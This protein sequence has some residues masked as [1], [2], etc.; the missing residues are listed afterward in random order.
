[1]AYLQMSTDTPPLSDRLALLR[2]RAAL[3]VRGEG[4]LP[5]A[6]GTTLHGAFGRALKLGVC[7]FPD[8][9]ERPCATCP[10]RESC[11]YPRLFEPPPRSRGGGAPPPAVGLAPAPATPRLVRPGAALGIDL[12]LIGDAMP[13]LSVLLAAL[14]RMA[15]DGLGPD[16]LPCAVLRVDA[17]DAAGR[18]AAP[19][20]LGAH[21]LDR[22][23]AA[24]A[25][26]AWRER[27][28]GLADHPTMLTLRV[29]TRLRLQREHVATGAAPSFAELARALVRRADALARSHCGEDAPFPD[30]R[31]WLD[32]AGT[33]RLVEARI[34]W[35]R[36][37][38]RS[39]STGHTM[40]LDGFTGTLTYA[41]EPGVLE[42][43][44]PL[45]LLGEVIGVG[46]G[47]SF[48]NGRYTVDLAPV[49]AEREALSHM[50][51]EAGNI[52]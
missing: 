45:L 17:L 44:L 52:Q 7:A 4:T 27:A 22:A 30:P 28:A 33:V 35:Q 29:A 18:S 38:R 16:R 13:A 15:T 12:A 25:P 32:L 10:L 24:L 23:P 2:L 1:M 46:R 21:P 48:G 39:A 49:V 5:V 8:P 50:P 34:G 20:Q 31:P 11:A 40:P 9:L 3:A 41:A 43:F 36:H 26:A 37:L 19:V 6:F 51:D 47:C 42:R 14:A